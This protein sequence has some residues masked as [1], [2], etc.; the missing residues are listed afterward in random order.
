MVHRVLKT[1]RLGYK[2]NGALNFKFQLKSNESLDYLEFKAYGN[3][4]EESEWRL[5]DW[6][7]H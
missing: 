4:C 7:D 5:V 3:M 6:S 1:E 2:K